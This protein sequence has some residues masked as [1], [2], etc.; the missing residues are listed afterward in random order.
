MPYTMPEDPGVR[1]SYDVTATLDAVDLAH[2]RLLEVKRFV[3][4]LEEDIRLALLYHVDVLSH[5]I[6]RNTGVPI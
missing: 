5:F 3:P 1:H 2:A 4:E 6:A